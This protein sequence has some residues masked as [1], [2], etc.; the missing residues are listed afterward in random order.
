MGSSRDC[1]IVLSELK[2]WL[3]QKRRACARRLHMK[4]GI[5][6]GNKNGTK[7]FFIKRGLRRVLC[8]RRSHR[9]PGLHCR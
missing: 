2:D 9:R 8:T 7:D 1:E 4:G 5:E 6:R 3:K